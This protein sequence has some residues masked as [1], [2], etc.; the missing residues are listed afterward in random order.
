[1]SAADGYRLE[2][3]SLGEVRVP[4]EALYGAQ[5]ARAVENFPISG[6]RP[7]RAFIWSMATVKRAAAE[8]NAALGLLEAK[9]AEAIAG[10]AEEVRAGQWDDHFVVDP[11]QAG[12][13]TSHNMNTNEVIA[14]RAS[15]LMGGRLG[16][17]RVHPND[18]VNMAQSTNDTIPTAIR[19]GCLW[20][21][22]ELLEVVGD[23]A[24]AL[25]R[26][27]EAFD[28]IVKSGRTHL[29]DAVPIR[30]GQEFGGYATAVARDGDRI[31][32]SAEGLRRLG[33]GGTAVGTGL[34]AHPEYHAR[35][36]RR[37]S[38]LTGRELQTCDNL[39]EAMQSMADMADFSASLR[40]LAITLTRIANDFR[41]LASGP[42]TGL[43]ELR[44]PAMQPGSSIMPGKVNP[45]Q[46][47]MLN[48]A[49]FHVIG[50]D[51]TVAL[52]AQAGQ[53]ELNVMMPVIAH[54]LF[55]MMQVAIGAVRSFTQR[56][57]LGLQ[58]NPAR[59]TGWLERNAIVATALTP[60]IGYA[61]AAD[62]V[63]RAMAESRSIRELAEE[64]AAAG[65]LTSIAGS[66]RTVTVEEVNRALGDL[67][68]LTDGGIHGVGGG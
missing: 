17:Y 34:N 44:L 19:L 32:R 28:P 68:A 2:R 66:G 63:K 53:L 57:V 45:V 48:M 64:Q 62:L 59:A 3:D 18:H 42:A 37:L 30:L 23:L 20:R 55:E 56:A 24:L 12:A 36:V 10:A 6:L 22:D 26:K 8:V 65:R 40:T 1:M 7:Y 21:L 29:Q 33:I 13:G 39:F 52:G 58:A 14:N 15:Q 49:M 9:A 47:E 11:F 54:N 46:A 50:C 43:D 31:R 16:E 41:L 4:Q 61:A 35:M 5:T 60:L 38:E 67:R 25:Q 27:A 51:T